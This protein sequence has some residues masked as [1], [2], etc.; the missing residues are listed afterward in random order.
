VIEARQNRESSIEEARRQEVTLLTEVAGSVELASEIVDR[1]EELEARRRA[2]ADPSEMAQ[3]ELEVQRLLERAGGE[4]GEALLSAG[5][6]RWRRHMNERGLAT[7]LTGQ[8]Q[9][10]EA[11]PALY[12]S[13]AYFDALLDVIRD[14]RVY[15]TPHDLESLRIRMD[16]IDQQ[17]G[18]DV[19]DPEAGADMN[20]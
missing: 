2:G 19:F 17:R 6:Q 8:E 18:A 15:L 3:A 7:L 9:A 4:A 14:A 12:R 13:S 1:L 16:L 11:S 20:Q 5:A 10:Y